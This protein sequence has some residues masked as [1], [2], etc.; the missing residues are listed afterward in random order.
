MAGLRGRGVTFRDFT[1][2][3][4]NLGST[5]GTSGTESGYMV[6]VRG[7]VWRDFHVEY[8]NESA[9]LQSRADDIMTEYEASVENLDTDE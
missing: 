6:R 8:D 4:N 5:V 7:T 9:I 2:F 1:E 3:V